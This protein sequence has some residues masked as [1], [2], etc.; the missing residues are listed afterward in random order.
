MPA[1]LVSVITPSYNQAHFIRAT[2][3]SILAQDYPNIE[4][5]IMDGGSNDGTAEV[6]R[7]Y[8]SRVT[9]IS[10]RDRGQSDAIN[11]GFRMARGEIVSWLNSDDIIL[12][13]AVSKAVQRLEADPE[14][15]AVY[16]EGYQMDIDGRFTCRFPWTEPFNLWKL[17]HVL[18]YILQQTVYFRKSALA[19]VN[20]LNE[21]LHWGMDWDLLIRIGQRYPIGYIPEFMGAIREYDTAKSFSGG[22]RRF[23]E[24]MQIVRTHSGKK[25]PAAY[26]FYGLSTYDR[27]LNEAIQ[28]RT[29]GALQRVS[30]VVQRLIA[31]TC[32]WGV[33]RVYRNAQGWYTDG[34]AGPRV[35]YMLPPTNGSGIDISG[36]LPRI[37]RKLPKQT[38]QVSANGHQIGRFSFGPGDF[39][40]HAQLPED[41]HNEAI[42]LVLEAAHSFVPGRIGADLDLRKLA[43]ILSAVS[44][45]PRSQERY[46]RA[47]ALGT[48]PA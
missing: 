22:R 43:Y 41:L 42:E 16:G 31:H 33:R 12:P 6:V 37:G 35:H 13:G 20:Y 3:E 32:A 27:V 8:S 39:S 34:W 15:G 18:D 47:S 11:K 2:I 28:A 9:W 21:A 23:N 29:P 7:E 24:L 19:E 26:L 10:G 38:V 44:P 46:S 45:A 4:Y 14:L 17:V 36:T 40:F 30:H 5:I 48:T 1:P 25:Y